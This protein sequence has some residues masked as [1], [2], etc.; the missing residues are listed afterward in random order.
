MPTIRTTKELDIRMKAARAAWREFCDGGS[1][2]P[3][4][5]ATADLFDALD[6]VYPIENHTVNPSQLSLFDDNEKAA[7]V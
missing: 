4:F 2:L 1:R 7:G 6:M 5:E 3:F